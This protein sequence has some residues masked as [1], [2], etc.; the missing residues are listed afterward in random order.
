MEFPPNSIAIKLERMR[1]A[2]GSIIDV[3]H[4]GKPKYVE[5]VRYVDY[6]VFLPICDGEI[7]RGELLGV[8]KIILC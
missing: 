1:H 4:A 2:Y 8:I 6:A 7:R 5:K 3:L